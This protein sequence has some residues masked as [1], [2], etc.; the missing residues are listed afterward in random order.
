M[1]PDRKH[2]REAAH[3]RAAA[4][5]AA[6]EAHRRGTQRIRAIIASV[7]AVAVL[8]GIAFSFSG[9]G[10]R[11]SAPATAT[12]T[13][14]ITGDTTTSVTVP[15]GPFEYGTGVCPPDTP[16]AEKPTTFSA[17]PMN[18]LD[19]GTDYSAEV[20]TSEGSFTIDLLE[21]RAPGTVNNFVVLARY[22]FFD[23]LTF[24]RVVPGFM[25]QGGDPN[26]D[27]RGGPGYSIADELPSAVSDY[28]PGAVAMANSGPN[29]N[30]SQWFTCVD[31]SVLQTASYS[32]FGQVT[33]GMD[34]VTAINDLGTGETPPSRTITITSITIQEQ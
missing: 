19:A 33:A 34:V 13:T 14:T 21:D 3:R 12:T 8:A 4:Q 18:C 26:G 15:A 2:G 30:G 10:S 11:A 7:V 24:H 9:G 6:R 29:T 20:V 16:A 31:C 25:N 32:L 22:G 1:S 17:A 23:G 28:V 27:G 5:A